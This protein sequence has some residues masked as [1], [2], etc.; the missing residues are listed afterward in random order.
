MRQLKRWD[1]GEIIAEGPSIKEI[2]EKCARDRVSMFRA[3]LRWTDLSRANLTRAVLTGADLT[4]A[5]LF[6]ADLRWTDLTRADLTRADLT[7]A[8][9]VVA[10]YGVGK[11]HRFGYIWMRKGVPVASLGWHWEPELDTMRAIAKEYGPGS[12]YQAMVYGAFRVLE[13]QY[14]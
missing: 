1:T 8:S 2:V 6:R 14:R 5:N 3:N 10:F 4:G 13:E 9:G 7:G 12:A 11:S